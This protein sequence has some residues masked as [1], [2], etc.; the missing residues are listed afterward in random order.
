MVA[1]KSHTAIPPLGDHLTN[2]TVGISGF[3]GYVPERV[4]T[5]EDW[6]EHVDT[7]DEWIVAR[8]GIHRRR[9]AAEGESTRRSRHRRRELGP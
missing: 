2:N 6:T 4:M 9:F 5:N 1:W 7:S 3:G 8:T